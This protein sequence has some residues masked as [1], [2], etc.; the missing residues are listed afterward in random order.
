MEEDNFDDISFLPSRHILI[1]AGGIFVA[2]LALAGA[3]WALAEIPNNSKE[4]T[5]AGS[6]QPTGRERPTPS[7]LRQGMQVD[8]SKA[9][10]TSGR[11]AITEPGDAD[12]S[13]AVIRDLETIIGNADATTLVGRRVDLHVP[14]L[15]ESSLVTFWV[16]S[17]DK[18]LLVV[19]H[20]DVRDG[21]E[22]QVSLPP[23]HG[24]VAIEHSQQATIS[25]TLQ[26]APSAEGRFSWD[27]TAAQRRDLEKRGVD[28]L[29]DSVRTAG[30]GE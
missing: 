24:I 21:H 20:R 7:T 26:R 2:V 17:S 6:L 30:P 11:T 4:L 16:G 25:G 13:P 3:I 12:A 23:A 8:P 28:L 1:K 18:P 29:A 5:Y 19:L 27:L 14:V 15:R 22:R 9:I 10:G